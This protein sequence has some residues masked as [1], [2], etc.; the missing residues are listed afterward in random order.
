MENFKLNKYMKKIFLA[1][2]IFVSTHAFSQ[3]QSGGTYISDFPIV[4]TPVSA[5][6]GN[7]INGDLSKYPTIKVTITGTF[8]A[9]IAVQVSN[10]AAFTI[11]NSTQVYSVNSSSW[12]LGSFNTT[13]Q[14][15]CVSTAGFTY[16]RIRAVAYTSGTVNAII[17]GS[18]Y[19]T[20]TALN[21]NDFNARTPTNGQK[22]A[23]GSLPVVLPS[24]T[25]TDVNTD[26]YC[27]V[28]TGTPAAAIGDKIVQTIKNNGGTVS[29]NWFNV[30]QSVL[31]SVSPIVANLS[32]TPIK[33]FWS[34]S[35]NVNG[36]TCGTSYAICGGAGQTNVGGVVTSSIAPST[37][38]TVPVGKKLV[39]TSAN[40]S[41]WCNNWHTPNTTADVSG[42]IDIRATNSTGALYLSLAWSTIGA[43]GFITEATNTHTPTY[44]V[45]STYPEGTIE[46]PSGT[47]IVFCG[48]NA[49]PGGGYAT[50]INI[51]GAVV[52]Y[53][54]NN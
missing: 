2:I 21:T 48:G 34:W 16:M 25:T 50:G 53:L 11:F 20:S 31:F 33:T 3:V 4:S 8:V 40:F 19:P 51:Q 9:T 14:Q 22:V 43:N 27:R 24:N 35:A 37:G 17:F 46:I 30:T 54:V 5:L 36:M 42:I 41:G 28:A 39:I 1:A 47:Q 23:T 26:W 12:V 10:D 32:L 44:Q 6:N 52:G 29:V 18:Y 45:N 15:F 49:S 13:G 38:Y 7:L